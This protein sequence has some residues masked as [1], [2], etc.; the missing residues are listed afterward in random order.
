[1][2]AG[3]ACTRSA[4]RTRTATA[5]NGVPLPLGYP[6]LISCVPSARFE[7]AP[8]AS[9]T[10][11]LC[12]L[13]HEGVRRGRETADRHVGRVAQVFPAGEPGGR[14]TRRSRPVTSD[15][16]VPAT[17]G[18]HAG[19]QEC[20]I[21]ASGIVSGNG[22]RPHGAG[23]SRPAP[24][25]AGGWW[26]RRGVSRGACPVRDEGAAHRCCGGRGTARPRGAATVVARRWRC[27]GSSRTPFFRSGYDR[28]SRTDR[29]G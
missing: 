20:E 13:G 29:R 14:R 18:P 9:S 8:P 3:G 4:T 26:S 19:P 10:P 5:L 15:A 28:N 2:R 12:R 27:A 25:R 23:K 21:S 22:F 16:L 1:M 17:S 11:G 7:R 24:E 6:G